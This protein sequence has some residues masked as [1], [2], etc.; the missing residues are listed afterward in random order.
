MSKNA[1]VPGSGAR[2]YRF[3]RM[4]SFRKLNRKGVPGVCFASN[5]GVNVSRKDSRRGRL[6]LAFETLQ[7]IPR[8]YLF[9]IN[10]PSAK[11]KDVRCMF[12]S[13]QTF[14]KIRL[15]H[16]SNLFRI[17]HAKG[18]IEKISERTDIRGS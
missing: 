12:K 7:L 9:V 5:Q 6:G 17:G 14:I 11:I 18:L 16:I 10:R 13:S 8:F 3:T 1:H 15:E 2:T 4:V